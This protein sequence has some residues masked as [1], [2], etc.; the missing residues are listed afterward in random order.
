MT[1]YIIDI[2]RKYMEEG[3]IR[4]PEKPTEAAPV[5]ISEIKREINSALRKIQDMIN[6]YTSKID[7]LTRK[8]AEMTEKIE[9]LES[10]IRDMQQK[11]AEEVPERKVE[12]RKTALDYLKVDGYVLQKDLKWLRKPEA[13]FAKLKREGAIVV[14]GEKGYIAIDREFYEELVRELQSLKTADAKEALQKISPKARKLLEALLN[15]GLVIYDSNTKSWKL[16]I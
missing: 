16:T 5:D 10:L 6:P 14:E 11:G 12:R 3:A 9:Y 15:E 8:T 13:F 2:I 7:D 1:E 4:A